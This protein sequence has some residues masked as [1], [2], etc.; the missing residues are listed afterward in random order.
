MSLPTF[1]KFFNL[2]VNFENVTAVCI[3][4]TI[5]FYCWINQEKKQRNKK[6][7]TT[8]SPC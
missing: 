8:N 1:A 7:I 4:K 6:K 2:K 3:L 5:D